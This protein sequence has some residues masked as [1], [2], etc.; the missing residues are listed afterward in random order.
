MNSSAAEAHERL[1]MNPEFWR[2]YFPLLCDEAKVREFATI[3]G[4]SEER[5]RTAREEYF[6]RY[7]AAEIAP[8]YHNGNDT[9]N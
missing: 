6:G 1:M 7:V 5:I 8:H 4:L 3:T 9:V 2:L